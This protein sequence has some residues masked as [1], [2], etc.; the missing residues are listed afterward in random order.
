L[1]LEL[2]VP[3]NYDLLTS[4]HAWIYPDIQPVPEQTGGTFFARI[5]DV[6]HLPVPLFINQAQPGRRISV[7]FSSPDVSE[8]RVRTILQE[9]LGLNVR[10]DGA[11]RILRDEPLLSHVTSRVSGIQPYLSPS[12]Y[13]ALAKTIIQQQISYRAANILTKRIVTQLSHKMAFQDMMLYSFPRPDAILKCG[14]D[15]LRTFGLGYKSEYI[16]EIAKLI[17]DGTLRTESLKGKSFDEVFTVLKPIRGIGTWTIRTL[18]IAGL[19]DYSVF[20]HD[21]LGVRNM[22]GRLFKKDG[23]RLT[24]SEVES[25]TQQWGQEWPLVLYLLMCADVLGF[26]GKDGRQQMHKRNSSEHAKR[27]PG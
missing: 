11:L 10:M 15:G 1:T 26:L 12:V 7:N 16:Y 6:N 22:M 24:P 21:D 3:R 23:K 8:K 18:A 25:Y 13:E 27:K 19:G 5:Y 14:V 17:H 9:V 4:V 20:P 2:K